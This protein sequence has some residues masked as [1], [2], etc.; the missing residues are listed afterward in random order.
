MGLWSQLVRPTPLQT[1]TVAE[2]YNVQKAT[3]SLSHASIKPLFEKLKQHEPLL[4]LLDKEASPIVFKGDYQFIEGL[5]FVRVSVFKIKDYEQMDLQCCLTSK[6]IKASVDWID[7]NILWFRR[8]PTG[9]ES[10]IDHIDE[11]RDHFVGDGIHPILELT[12][13]LPD[14]LQ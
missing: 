1:K 2:T 11:Y 10:F 9:Y 5:V 4:K 13:S 6:Y 14:S 8:T 7:N 12:L 3:R